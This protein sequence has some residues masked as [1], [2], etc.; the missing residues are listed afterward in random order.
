MAKAG[1]ILAGFSACIMTPSRP[2]SLRLASPRSGAFTLVEMLVVIGI[3]LLLSAIIFPVFKGIQERGAQTTCASNMQQIYLAVRLY[4]DDERE[5]PASLAA[6]LPDTEKLADT[7][8][9]ATDK[10]NNVE[11]TGYFRKTREELVCPDDDFQVADATVAGEQTAVRSSYGDTTNDPTKANAASSE[12]AATANVSPWD[13]GAHNKA[14]YAATDTRDWGRLSWNFWGY[15]N[16]GQAFRSEAE[17]VDYFTNISATQD[18]KILASVLR[19]PDKKS[20]SDNFVTDA[21]YTVGGRYFNPRGF[22]QDK[23]GTGAATG[24]IYEELREA[25]MFKYSLANSQAPLGTIIT[26]CS[27]HRLLT[28][29]NAFA[30]GANQIY[31]KTEV[32]ALSQTDFNADGSDGAGARD[33]I[34]RLDGTARSY[35]VSKWND[36]NFPRA[37]HGSNW[38][39]SDF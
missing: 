25:N 19:S 37:T 20:D 14:F 15:D 7:G 4:K 38:Q 18:P 11:G 35:D 30:P 27:F 24:P 1:G 29:Q 9:D 12:V 31:S 22:V 10:G 36:L 16:W 33:I 2:P 39:N 6:L 17:A 32:P 13:K 21:K 5:Y 28:A 23:D 34:L 3:I 8:A 26:H